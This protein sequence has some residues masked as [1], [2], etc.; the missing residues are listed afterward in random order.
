MKKSGG[1]L[2]KYRMNQKA[3]E[4]EESLNEIEEDIKRLKEKSK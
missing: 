2:E 4:R 3:I 1:E